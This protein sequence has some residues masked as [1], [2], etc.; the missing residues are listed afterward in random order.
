MTRKT[1]VWKPRKEP[2]L[3]LKDTAGCSVEIT[4]LGNFCNGQ[5]VYSICVS[6]F[7]PVLA[8]KGGSVNEFN[9]KTVDTIS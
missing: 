8:L 6:G 1:L 7:D 5:L 4:L 9:G 2:P 3:Q